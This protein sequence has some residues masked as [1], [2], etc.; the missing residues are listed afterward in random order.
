MISNIF[1]V[2]ITNKCTLFR[3]VRYICVCSTVFLAHTFLHSTVGSLWYRSA[4]AKAL[5]A[6]WLSFYQILRP[7]KWMI[8]VLRRDQQTK[9]PLFLLA[10]AFLTLFLPYPSLKAQLQ[11]FVTQGKKDFFPGFPAGPYPAAFF[12]A[13]P[14]EQEALWCRHIG[15]VPPLCRFSLFLDNRFLLK[16]HK[17]GENGS[18]VFLYV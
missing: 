13:L 7:F 1:M 14:E 4:R 5:G 11:S 18:H 16:A 2:D 17:T 12:L 3:V 8:P 10:F 9:S 6:A 15:S